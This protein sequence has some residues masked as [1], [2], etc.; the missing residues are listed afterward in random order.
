MI[1]HHHCAIFR[2]LRRIVILRARF[3]H[4]VVAIRCCIFSS[5]RCVNVYVDVCACDA[6]NWR[7]SVRSAGD[8]ARLQRRRRGPRAAQNQTGRARRRRHVGQ[9]YVPTSMLMRLQNAQNP[10]LRG[11]TAVGRG[12]AGLGAAAAAAAAVNGYG[13]RRFVGAA[14]CDLPPLRS[15]RPALLTTVT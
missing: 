12:Q 1:R 8:A 7:A 15:R 6:R 10:S 4:P 13:W 5:L 2:H 14:N 3:L 11:G 9:G